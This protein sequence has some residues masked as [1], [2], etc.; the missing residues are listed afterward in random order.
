MWKIV[1]T[2]SMTQH[3]GS[4]RAE[5]AYVFHSCSPGMRAASLT[6]SFRHSPCRGAIGLLTVRAGS[7]AGQVLAV[8]KGIDEGMHS[9]WPSAPKCS[10]RPALLTKR[11]SNG[12]ASSGHIY[13]YNNVVF[14]NILY[15]YKHPSSRAFDSVGRGSQQ[16]RMNRTGTLR[17]TRPSLGSFCVG[18]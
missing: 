12:S 10:R 3:A 14:F 1:G 15:I 16:K 6:S 17:R 18:A 8:A 13:I 4:T 11:P 9:Y 2:C 7:L 5:N